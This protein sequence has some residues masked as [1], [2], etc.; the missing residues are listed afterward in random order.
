VCQE[1]RS[2]ETGAP[3]LTQVSEVYSPITVTSAVWSHGPAMFRAMRQKRI[4]WP[5]FHG[6]EMADLIAYLNSR[7]TTRIA[8]TGN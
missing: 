7:L 6:S 4:S 8:P 1:E 5:E 2:K 3:Y